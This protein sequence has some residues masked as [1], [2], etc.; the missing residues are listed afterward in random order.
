MN[1][2]AMNLASRWKRLGGVLIDGVLVMIITFPVMQITGVLEQI[3]RGEQMTIGQQFTSTLIGAVIFL[4]LNG[5]L[6]FKKGQTIGKL[7]V[8]IRIVDH[9]GNVPNIGKLLVLRSYIF[10]LTPY[11]PIVGPLINLLD[12]V[13]IFN[14]QRRCLHD[15]LAGTWVIN[16]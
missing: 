13:L 16:A 14:K 7:A 11:I 8:K 4:L 2:V 12:G 10:G 6:L 1:E 15:Y 5:Y 9:D 3:R